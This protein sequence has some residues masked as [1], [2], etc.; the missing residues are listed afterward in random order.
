MSNLGNPQQLIGSNNW[1]TIFLRI[2][3]IGR[4]KPMRAFVCNRKG[5]KS[6]RQQT[7]KL[8]QTH[9]DFGFLAV[10]SGDTGSFALL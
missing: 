1:L 9:H 8:V 7:V 3:R 6:N 10:P 5:A 2:G 4:I